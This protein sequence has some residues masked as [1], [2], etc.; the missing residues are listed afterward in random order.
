MEPFT[1]TVVGSYPR[2]TTVEDML[3][4]PAVSQIRAL[5]LSNK[6][7]CGIRTFRA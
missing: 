7:I 5:A 4:K 2:S 6:K 1:A 3:K